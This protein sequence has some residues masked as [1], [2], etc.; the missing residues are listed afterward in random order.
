MLTSHI[1]FRLPKCN[2]KIWLA[3]RG[4]SS[5]HVRVHCRVEGKQT[6][7]EAQKGREEY[8]CV[9]LLLSHFFGIYPER[10]SPR[11]EADAVSRDG[12]EY[13]ISPMFFV[14]L[15]PTILGKSSIDSQEP[16]SHPAIVK[17]FQAGF[18]VLGFRKSISLSLTNTSPLVFCIWYQILIKQDLLH[19]CSRW[20]FTLSDNRVLCNGIETSVKAARGISKRQQKG[21][22]F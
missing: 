17:L 15:R 14:I 5:S 12:L 1:F 19:I 7:G 2:R 11:M 22:C 13:P 16:P 8:T 3:F 10:I 20:I 4:T 21:C 9:V 18:R 6:A